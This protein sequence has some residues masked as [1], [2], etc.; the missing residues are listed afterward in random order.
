MASI[1][2]VPAR[3]LMGDPIDLSNWSPHKTNA[4]RTQLIYS[5]S[6]SRKVEVLDNVLI[7]QLRQN[8][9]ECE[10]VKYATDQIM[11]NSRPE[12]LSHILN[13]LNRNLLQQC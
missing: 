3:K 7:E 4:V 5:E 1:F 12:I 9:R 11:Y 6:T 2:A 8:K 13:K 10:I